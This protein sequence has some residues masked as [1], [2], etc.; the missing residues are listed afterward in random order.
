M[1]DDRTDDSVLVREPAATRDGEPE[2]EQARIA[3]P[4]VR[5]DPA[6]VRQLIASVTEPAIASSVAAPA[7]TATPLAR[8]KKRSSPNTTRPPGPCPNRYLRLVSE[9][10][11]KPAAR[12]TRLPRTIPGFVSR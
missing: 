4:T 5:P 7:A 12:V 2:H 6:R 9:A 11:T 10:R 8:S 1:T 3:G